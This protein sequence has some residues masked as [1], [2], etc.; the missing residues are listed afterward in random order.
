VAQKISF[1]LV[2]KLEGRKVVEVLPRAHSRDEAK[3]YVKHA[4]RLGRKYGMTRCDLFV[5]LVGMPP[6][7]RMK[8]VA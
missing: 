2:Q 4:S 7:A 6:K 8:V 1:Y 3:A 5:D